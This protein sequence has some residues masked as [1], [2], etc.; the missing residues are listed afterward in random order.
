MQEADR[1]AA[2]Q[3]ERLFHG[4][5]CR[6]WELVDAPAASHQGEQAIQRADGVLVGVARPDPD[7]FGLP[8]DAQ[9]L[10]VSPRDPG[11]PPYL[12]TYSAADDVTRA[13]QRPHVTV[14]QRLHT[15]FSRWLT[16]ALSTATPRN[17]ALLARGE[18][19][20]LG[21]TAQPRVRGQAAEG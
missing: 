5:G 13:L 20:R 8:T 4:P 1:Q 10:S 14:G 16:G 18:C 17:G 12:V 21:R 19:A 6:V 11:C 3:I 9:L 15:L 2:E 7:M